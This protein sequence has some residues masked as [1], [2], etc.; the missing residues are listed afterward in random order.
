MSDSN[1]NQGF[2]WLL[3][4]TGHATASRFKDVLARLKPK[5]E[6]QRGEPAK[7]RQDYLLQLVT[8]RLTGEPT[9]SFVNQA[10]Q[11]GID[12]EAFAR[13]RYIAET[14]HAVTLVGFVRH[15]ELMAGASPDGVIGME[16]LVEIKCP[17]STTHVE[18][19]RSGMD[20]FHLPQIQGQLW[21]TGADWCDFVSYDPRLPKGLDLHIERVARDDAFIKQLEGEV[22]EFLAEVD[23]EIQS[24]RSRSQ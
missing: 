15:P 17:T 9:S 14:G 4:R 5:K 21:I 22:R 12:N 6:G 7:V 13:E 10:M 20:E 8:E 1:P 11:W 18:T 16:G 23:V 3:E 2:A 24:L 19:L